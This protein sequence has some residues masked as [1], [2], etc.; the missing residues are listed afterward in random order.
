Q[1]ATD[2]LYLNVS[3]E[4]FRGV[5][6]STLCVKKGSVLASLFGGCFDGAVVRDSTDRIFLPAYPPAFK[7]LAEQLRYYELG[8]VEVI[9]LP[10][11]KQTDLPHTYW[12]DALLCDPSAPEQSPPPPDNDSDPQRTELD[13]THESP[14][15]DPLPAALRISTE[16]TATLKQI[17][18]AKKAE[19]ARLDAIKP[20]LETSNTDDDQLVSID[21][22]GSS[23]AITHAVA[24]SLGG[25]DSTF[26]GRFT[27]YNGSTDCGLDCVRRVVDVAVRA[28]QERR[29]I[30]SADVREAMGDV[31]AS[32]F[33][34]ALD[35][36]GIGA[37][38]YLGPT[39]GL[40]K[41]QH[42]HNIKEWRQKQKWGHPGAPLALPVLPSH[43][44]EPIERI[45]KASVDGWRWLDFV[46]AVRGQK[47]LI[48]IMRVKDS[49]ELS[50]VVLYDKIE[51]SVIARL[52]FTR[53]ARLEQ[54]TETTDLTNA[55]SPL[56][57]LLAPPGMDIGIPQGGVPK[58]AMDTLLNKCQGFAVEGSEP[59][60]WASW[61]RPTVECRA[62]PAS[63]QGH[64]VECLLG[65]FRPVSV[66]G[67]HFEL[68]EME[69]Y[70]VAS[71]GRCISDMKWKA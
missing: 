35:V 50:A 53:V 18:Q 51:V 21:V 29:T 68:D 43:V 59:D 6:R 7:W 60:D 4:I 20:F 26:Y 8:D 27:R 62:S 66:L 22:L 36:F 23:V 42:L 39:D 52:T 15:A 30:T 16:L 28:H 11:A 31:S 13:N 19:L 9:D 55:P 33:R 14:A 63:W 5:R 34:R 64:T 12:V 47:P 1:M 41:S 67:F 69:V 57:C 54:K 40:L 3:G 48:I 56:S 49:R 38:R 61:Q 24:K 10:A 17:E 46:D 45:Y 58:A 2:K 65:L 71:V 32:Q 25:E 37:D 44:G 70:S